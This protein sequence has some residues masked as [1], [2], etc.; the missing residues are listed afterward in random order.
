M[1]GLGFM[2]R[3]HIAAYQHARQAGYD[4]RVAA[5]CDRDPHRCDPGS[6]P[7]AN[8]DPA[9]AA[10]FL[11][12]DLRTCTAPDELLRDQN[13]ALVSIC[14]PTDTHVDLALDALRAHKHVLVEKPLAVRSAD[15]QRVVAAAAQ[16]TTLCM[17]ALCMRF[18][19]AWTWL[20]RQIEANTFGPVR[21]ATFQRLGALPDWSRAFYEDRAR[22]GGM[23]VDLHIHDADFVR[24]CFGDPQQVLCTGSR[25]HI[26]THYRF[27]SGPDHVA[28]EGAW[29]Q[30]AGCPFRMRFVVNFEHATADFDLD[31][32]QQ[33]MLAR[34]SDWSPVA[35]DPWTGW[36]GQVRHFLDAVA[37]HR[38]ALDPVAARHPALDAT[39][40]DAACVARLLEAEQRSLETGQAVALAAFDP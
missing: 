35:L 4:C 24:W 36:E 23:L 3:I 14:T 5:V 17:P 30:Q 25:D 6:A 27:A 7:P 37:A 11:D 22:S 12:P 18:W 28:A 13:L 29:D 21:S 8:L 10:A 26:T 31:R 1:I 40:A 19:P 33:L 20:K 9:V 15:A 38:P 32:P 16:A 39:V 34:G 2:G